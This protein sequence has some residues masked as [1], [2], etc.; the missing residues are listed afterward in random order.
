MHLGQMRPRHRVRTDLI[1]QIVG[2]GAFDRS[3]EPHSPRVGEESAAGGVRGIERWQREVGNHI[4][5]NSPA[6]RDQ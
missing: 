6:R 4:G 5:G 1:V 2:R 3:I